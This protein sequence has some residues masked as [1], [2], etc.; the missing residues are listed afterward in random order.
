M[1]EETAAEL[2]KFK[3]DI[4]EAMKDAPEHDIFITLSICTEAFIKMKE[5]AIG[6]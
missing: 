5:E 1:D 4:L 6:R 3:E 2:K